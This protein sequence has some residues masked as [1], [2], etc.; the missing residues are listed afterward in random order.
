V[1]LQADD[2]MVRL[3]LEVPF[4]TQPMIDGCTTELPA[5]IAAAT[6]VASDCDPA[7]WWRRHKKALPHWFAMARHCF[8]LCPSSAAAERVFS[9]MKAT[10]G[11][12]QDMAL[13]DGMETTLMV[14]YNDRSSLGFGRVK[15]GMTL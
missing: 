6:G 15:E 11:D 2:V 14:Q 12:Q 1:D 5:Y 9:L 4:V 7:E 13:E 10:F 8:H 3:L